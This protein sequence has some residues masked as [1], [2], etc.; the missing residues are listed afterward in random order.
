MQYSSRIIV[1]LYDYFWRFKLTPAG[2]M[3][4]MAMLLSAVGSVSIEIPIYQVFCGLLGLLMVTEPIGIVMRPRLDVEGNLPIRVRADEPFTSHLRVT[5]RSWKPAF[6]LMAGLFGL[7]KPFDHLNGDSFVP[8]LA[9]GAGAVLPVTLIARRRGV[10]RLPAV[11]IHSTFPFNLMRF[12]GCK[13]PAQSVTVFPAYRS[14]EHLDIPQS[15]RFQPGGVLLTARVGDSMEYIGN[16][17]YTPGE[18]VRR[19]DARAWA[20]L[21][22][23]VVREYQEEY[24]CRIA[25]ILD[26]FVPGWR[27]P[28]SQGFANLEAAVSL[29]AATAEAMSTGEFLVDFFAAGPNL[30]VFRSSG[31]RASFDS[32]LEILAS[33][34]AS[35]TDPFEQV[36]PA[37]A[38]EMLRISTAVCILL[39]WDE[40]RRQLAEHI[41]EAG[42]ALK[43]LI[44][45]DGETTL[46][47][48]GD[49]H[50][51][52][53]APAEIIRGNVRE[54]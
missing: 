39:D 36:S 13:L 11:H 18:P 2:R 29:T 52:Q 53:M 7:P 9:R 41:L 46:P 3:L 23:P 49:D 28:G 34:D 15:Q 16:R 32:V 38:E 6:D 17:E 44:V 43:V 33:V 37:V 22:R 5:N 4:V 27:R 26:T 40:P 24:S 31:S 48:G 25:I 35:R 1:P 54:V 19:L 42:C 45:R 30:H 50:L 8:S 51:Q 47:I 14:L 21:G 12:G 10:Y 20:R